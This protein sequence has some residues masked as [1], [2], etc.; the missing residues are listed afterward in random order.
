MNYERKINIIGEIDDNAYKE[1]VEALDNLDEM[2][3]GD[4]IT[5][6]LSSFGGD[7]LT[8]LAFYDRIRS[9]KSDVTIIATGLV[10]SAAVIILAAGD[11]RCMT[12]NAWVLVHED[13]PAADEGARVTSFERAA[14]IARQL[15]V[16]WNKIL[17]ERTGVS[18]EIWEDLHKQERYLT[19]IDCKKLKL[20]EKII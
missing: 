19:S 2:L 5:I 11:K 9:C 3:E 15:E 17:E 10:A 16:Q 12:K 13:M 4:D 7:A 18:E 20:I 14:K 1:F 8:A 6:E